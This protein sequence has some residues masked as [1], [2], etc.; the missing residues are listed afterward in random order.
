MN[1]ISLVIATIAFVLYK[2]RSICQ[3]EFGN[4]FIHQ[5]LIETRMPINHS[6]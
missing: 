6:Q 1:S 2:L 3:F 4:L 5:S